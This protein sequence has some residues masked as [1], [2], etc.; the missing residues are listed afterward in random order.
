MQTEISSNFLLHHIFL[1]YITNFFVFVSGVSL[2]LL[3]VC[4]RFCLFFLLLLL[5]DCRQ[6]RD[7]EKRLTFP[8]AFISQVL[9]CK[10]STVP[11]C[12]VLFL[13]FRS[14][15]CVF[16]SCKSSTRIRNFLCAL[17]GNQNARMSTVTLP[18][19]KIMLKH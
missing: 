13:Q 15:F 1:L 10:S 19:I 5:F 6:K 9:F 14:L 7:E 4:W 8:Q 17:F 3:F 2:L 16:A 18:R 11:C 12:K